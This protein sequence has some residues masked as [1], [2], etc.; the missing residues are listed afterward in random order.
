VTEK[1]NITAVCQTGQPACFFIRIDGEFSRRSFFGTALKKFHKKPLSSR[2]KVAIYYPC[3]S[4]GLFILMF[5]LTTI[6]PVL[7]RKQ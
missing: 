7:S 1:L 4:A 6:F 3:F 5:L 2:K